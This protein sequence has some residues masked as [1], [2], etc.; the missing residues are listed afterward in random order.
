MSVLEKYSFTFRLGE[1]DPELDIRRVVP[2]NPLDEKCMSQIRSWMGECSSTHSSCGKSEDVALPGRIIEVPA[3][4]ALLPKLVNSPNKQGKYIILSHCIDEEKDRAFTD[5]ELKTFENGI[6]TTKLPKVFAEAIAVTQKLGFQYLWIK[7]LCNNNDTPISSKSLASIYLNSSLLLSATSSPDIESTFLNPREILYSPPLGLHKNRFYRLR[8]LRWKDDIES[9]PLSH[10][11]FSGLE[12]ILAPRVVHF[13]KRQVIWECAGGWKYEAAGVE[14]KLVGS[15]QVRMFY[16]KAF[17][18][19]FLSCAQGTSVQEVGVESGKK[20]KE[21]LET[22]LEVWH[23]CADEFSRRTVG[24]PEMKIEVASV[25]ASVFDDGSMGHYLAGVWS[26]GIAFGLSWSKQYQNLA[27]APKYRAPSWSWASVDGKINTSFLIPQ[28]ASPADLIWNKEFLPKLVSH[29]M[30]P[31][32]PE[33][34]YGGVKEGS[35]ITLSGQTTSLQAL[36]ETFR[37][38]REMDITMQAILDRTHAFD[39]PCCAPRPAVDESKQE[40]KGINDFVMLVLGRKSTGDE[41]MKW[42][43]CLILRN[44]EGKE[45]VFE[46]VG[47]ALLRLISEAMTGKNL[48]QI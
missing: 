36:A 30:V 23:S 29:E 13:T 48:W 34:Q 45:G 8:L 47:E 20:E 46:R 32:D 22:R 33:N 5:E 44:V 35:S 7:S 28:E 2:E 25:L 17:V 9:S 18:Q 40:L 41:M 42:I 38:D 6:D 16:R 39:C 27:K 3:D 26:K 37:R 24:G 10:Q 19:P 14:D 12:R 43:V 31:L 11:V 15:G 4:L 21:R 1:K